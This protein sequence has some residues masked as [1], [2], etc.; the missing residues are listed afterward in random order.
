M[1]D[2]DHHRSVVVNDVKD[3]KGKSVQKG[4]T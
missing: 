1:N 2:A 3:A 4:A